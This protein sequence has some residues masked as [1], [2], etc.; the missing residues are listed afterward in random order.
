MKSPNGIEGLRLKLVTVENI[1]LAYL[2]Q[3]FYQRAI[4][5]NEPDFN[6]PHL[7]S[8]QVHIFLARVDAE[9]KDIRVVVL[10]RADTLDLPQRQPLSLWAGVALGWLA[11]L[12]ARS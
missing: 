10:D 7:S 4:T 1:E 6:A 2:R 9:G 11:R 3:L 8:E 5:F 12:N